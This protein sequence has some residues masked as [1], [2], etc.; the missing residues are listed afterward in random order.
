M[1]CKQGPFDDKGSPA[2]P[3]FD[4]T[5]GVTIGATPGATPAFK[6]PRDR[7]PAALNLTNLIMA[8]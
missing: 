7:Q 4:V 2:A 6:S 1:V 8:I 5:I 3:A